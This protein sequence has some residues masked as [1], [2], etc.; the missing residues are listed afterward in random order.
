M[1]T[2]N[3]V[4]EYQPVASEILTLQVA[5]KAESNLQADKKRSPLDEQDSCLGY[6]NT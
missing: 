3:W 1:H 4:F 6:I 5:K 2:F